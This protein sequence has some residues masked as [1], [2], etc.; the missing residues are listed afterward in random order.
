MD[1]APWEG[2]DRIA[3]VLQTLLQRTDLSPEA[4]ASALESA[5]A[6]GSDFETA[7]VLLQFV[8]A[9]PIDGALRAPF[10]RAAATINSAFERGRVLRRKTQSR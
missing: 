6:V 4:R 1:S 2:R 9:G 8:K 3:R 10:F 7:N 5:A